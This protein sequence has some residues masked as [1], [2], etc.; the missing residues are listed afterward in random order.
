V[1]GT[2]SA[3]LFQ[4]VQTPG[5]FQNWQEE[6]VMCKECSLWCRFRKM[7]PLFLVLMPQ[8]TAYYLFASLLRHMVGYS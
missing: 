3:G 7:A 1:S 4:E 2:D 8:L 6:R 5:D